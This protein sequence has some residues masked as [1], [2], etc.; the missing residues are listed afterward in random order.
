MT[1]DL[2]S[3]YALMVPR[4][5][6]YPTA[7]H[8]HDGIGPEQY[9]SW[10][11]ALPASSSLSLYVH[12]P[13]CDTMCWFCGC[14]TKV[15]QQYKPLVGYMD[16]LL[17][18]ISH[19][20]RL[21][22]DGPA[23]SHIHW[24]GGS[25]TILTPEDTLR[26]A[27]H[28]RASFEFTGDAE[29]AVEID[30]RDFDEGR[31]T[32]LAEAGLTRASIGVQDFDPRV[33][34]AINRIQTFEET[35]TAV[36]ALRGHGV[37]SIN[38]DAMYGLPHQGL[39]EVEHTLAQVLRLRPDR[40]ALFGYAHVPWMKSHQKLIAEDALPDLAARHAQA[41]FA[42]DYLGDAGYVRIGFDH[43]AVPG[44]SLA[45][46]ALAGN[47]KRNFQGYTTDEAASLIGLGASAI[48]RLPQGYVQ[49]DPATAQYLAKVKR[50]ELTAV[51]GVELSDDDKMRAWVI[52]RLICDMRL[53]ASEVSAEFGNAA[54]P[55]L[56][57]MAAMDDFV[58]DG[59]I[60]RTDDGFV[61]TDIGR[62]FVRT[63]C[64]RF[65][66]YLN[67]NAARHSVAV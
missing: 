44:D 40:V 15:T 21:V 55:I 27:A 30:P 25:P 48:S 35:E 33:Q 37:R 29:F 17:D 59:L 9:A 31:I 34:K 23:V 65:D 58:A 14:N 46:A 22:K 28:I 57:E 6:S 64:A 8:F 54:A 60:A 18:E 24:G 36:N 43:F 63:I 16:G 12:I 13:F 20:A 3:K 11:G 61:L 53:S 49:N 38:I 62:P 39:K 5:T 56:S 52:E 67:K 10:L 41:A 42:S 7:P 47:L 1:I 51:K 50:G 66:A 32:A 26:L 45:K 2:L 4:Y 19:V